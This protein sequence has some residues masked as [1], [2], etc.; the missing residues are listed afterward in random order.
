VCQDGV[1]ADSFIAR[2]NEVG[3]IRKVF[4]S[5]FFKGA[6]IDLN[7]LEEAET[8]V[9]SLQAMATV[10]N[11]W[12]VR[13][14]NPPSDEI[15]WTGQSHEFITNVKR[16]LGN[17][18]FSPHVMTQVDKL[19]NEGYVGKGVKIAVIDSGVSLLLHDDASDLLV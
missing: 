9:A 15:V 6:S 5:A 4:D 17:D 3:S 12:P 18:T 19:R 1:N 2:V 8:T 7:N 14:V 13:E 10:K 16:Q 11:I